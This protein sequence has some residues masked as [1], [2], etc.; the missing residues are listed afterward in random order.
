MRLKP[1]S[2]KGWATTPHDAGFNVELLFDATAQ[3]LSGSTLSGMARS[4]ANSLPPYANLPSLNL[5]LSMDQVATLSGA[6]HAPGFFT[7]GANNG[8]T[9][10]IAHQAGS[11]CTTGILWTLQAI[12]R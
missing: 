4:V 11:S 8:A 10:R 2:S 9:I 7:E 12:V 5:Q 1:D 6:W 3:D